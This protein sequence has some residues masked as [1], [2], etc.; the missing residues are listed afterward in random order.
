MAVDLYGDLMAT[1]KI[2]SLPH[3]AY[4]AGISPILA[5]G[6]DCKRRRQTSHGSRCALSL[7]PRAGYTETKIVKAKYHGSR[8]PASLLL[9]IG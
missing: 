5:A 8:K 7:P 9:R 6:L 3:R 2:G 1:T 4:N